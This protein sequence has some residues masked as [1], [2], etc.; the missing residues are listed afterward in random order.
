ME[1]VLPV[2]ISA[3]RMGASFTK[4]GKVEEVKALLGKSGIAT[5]DVELQVALTRTNFRQICCI[6]KEE[7][8]S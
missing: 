4:F 1:E 2:D 7:C 8:L 3:D 6:E 5:G